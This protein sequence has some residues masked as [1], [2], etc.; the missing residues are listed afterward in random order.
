M[1]DMPRIP[2][3]AVVAPTPLAVV[4][5]TAAL[6]ETTRSEHDESGVH[7]HP[8]GQGLW[9]A[10]MARSLGAEVTVIGPFGGELG[11]LVV[12]MLRDLDLTV[13]PV[14][15]P[16]GNGGYI[17]DLR[18]GERHVIAH[19]P[20]PPLSRHEFDDL[21]GVALV[22]GMDADLT[23][24]TGCEPADVLP[25]EFFERLIRDIRA[26][27]GRVVADLSGDA[28]LAAIRAEVD[29][30]KI[31]HDELL[32][33]ELADGESVPKLVAGARK[34]IDDGVGAVVVSRAE[35][36]ALVV[37][38]DGVHE[39]ITPPVSTHEHRGAGDSMTAGI[40]VGI[41]CGADLV[42]AT[43]LGA[44]AGALNVTRGGLGTGNRDTIER[45]AEHVEIKEH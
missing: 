34:L 37:D 11:P 2:R 36:P 42:D 31:A 28:A 25:A 39:L 14:P 22:E 43:R 18:A 5:A 38:A 29:V 10:R 45:I 26:S 9:M 44:A 33:A 20:P 27:G 7:I 35:K 41:A 24:I 15:Y 12:T 19:M 4:E 6:T 30:L 21:Y 17:Y 32:D 16:A 23:V 1:G 8:G 13:R 40:A 3:I